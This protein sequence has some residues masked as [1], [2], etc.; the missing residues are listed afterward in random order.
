MVVCLYRLEL[1]NL[2]LTHRAQRA[3][4]ELTE[5]QAFLTQLLAAA[6][7]TGTISSVPHSAVSSPEQRS[8]S[9]A[10]VPLPVTADVAPA[11]SPMP[12]DKSGDCS[13]SL[14][15][16]T[17][18]LP[19]HSLHPID[20]P[21][22]PFTKP[23]LPSGTSSLP[24]MN[25]L[26]PTGKV[27]M[28]PGTT[29]GLVPVGAIRTAPIQLSSSPAQS[30]PCSSYPHPSD[31]QTDTAMAANTT[32]DFHTTPLLTPLQSSV[33]QSRTSIERA[34]PEQDKNQT[35]HDAHEQGLKQEEE[36]AQ[37]CKLS[38][39]MLD[40]ATLQQATAQLAELEPH[41]DLSA[42]ER[43]AAACPISLSMDGLKGGNGQRLPFASAAA[44]SGAVGTPSQAPP[45]VKPTFCAGISNS[46][47]ASYP[48]SDSNP[49]GLSLIDKRADADM[50]HSANSAHEVVDKQQLGST[51]QQAQQQLGSTK[52]QAQQQQQQPEMPQRQKSTA[53][54][55]VQ[56]TGTASQHQL[57]RKMSSSL[58]ELTAPAARAGD[59][60]A[61][62]AQCGR[63]QSAG[64]ASVAA[65]IATRQKPSP[66]AA[67]PPNTLRPVVSEQ[68]HLD[69]ALPLL[70]PDHSPC[71]VDEAQSKAGDSQVNHSAVDLF[72][73]VSDKG[74]QDPASPCY[75]LQQHS[76]SP[77]DHAQAYAPAQHPSTGAECIL[78]HKLIAP[79]LAQPTGTSGST[80]FRL[81][82]SFTGE[83]DAS[84]Q[85]QSADEEPAHTDTVCSP[86][87]ASAPTNSPHTD[88]GAFAGSQAAW[89]QSAGTDMILTD[90]VSSLVPAV[91]QQLSGD[92]DLAGVS[93]SSI[94]Q[95]VDRML[96]EDQGDLS[97]DWH[98]TAATH[99]DPTVRSCRSRRL[100]V[101]TERRVQV[102]EHLRDM[103]EA[104]PSMMNRCKSEVGSALPLHARSSALNILWVPIVVGLA[105]L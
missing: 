87:I 16:A 12:H 72:C 84:A 80:G 75:A 71:D 90:R 60:T 49:H 104:L 7:P 88:S 27:G 82:N 33:S 69:A 86:P 54:A 89:Q 61:Q 56:P 26:L 25:C 57:L 15:V 63:S 2:Q 34:L 78:P 22:V 81:C 24:V 21:S 52:Q 42:T 18:G 77:D 96:I 95:Q 19:M 32:T 46:A 30:G 102:S 4:S 3:E 101:G 1:Q 73:M 105:A 68:G 13:N 64:L 62:L 9:I 76:P 58:P 39:Q 36:E 83:L 17:P 65:A 67:D 45:F 55:L 11:V 35:T 66:A 51:K 98:M 94:A 40:H 10:H 91:A 47:G 53:P 5:L 29:N 92:S 79:P 93:G 100:S 41:H 97:T 48:E 74:S 31:A 44:L 14:P 8:P 99:N 103:F 38:C 20:P 23:S 50:Q 70:K 6:A 37:I 85:Q 28:T 43:A 59:S